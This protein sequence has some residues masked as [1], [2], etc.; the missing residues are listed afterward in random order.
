MAP[1]KKGITSNKDD[2]VTLK[3]IFPEWN[4]EDLRSV[5]QDVGNDFESA[6]ARISEGHAEQWS[7]VSKKAKQKAGKKL[8]EEA[9]QTQEKVETKDE[10]KPPRKPFGE[11]NG[12]RGRGRGGS[13]TTSRGTGE[14]K[15]R[16]DRPNYSGPREQQQGQH[17]GQQQQGQH[18]Q[19]DQGQQQRQPGHSSNP[20]RG[21]FRS[22]LVEDL[23][24]SHLSGPM[25]NSLATLLI[26][27]MLRPQTLGPIPP[28]LGPKAHGMH[29]LLPQ[30]DHPILMPM[31][32]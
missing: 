12:T 32:I 10:T 5:L 13:Y 22:S 23:T 8:E 2:S 4:L 24:D 29:L 6:V 18:Q 25:S 15:P 31:V 30:M 19:Q 14:R 21:N 1:G 20:S 16:T 27:K 11:S 17:Q 7:S 26:V 28:L 9:A 3:E